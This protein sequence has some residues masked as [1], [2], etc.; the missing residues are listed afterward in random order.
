MATELIARSVVWQSKE[1]YLAVLFVLQPC[2]ILW[3]RALEAGD[4]AL[5]TG[6]SGLVELVRKMGARHMFLHGP[7]GSG[8]TFCMTEVVLKVVRHYFGERGVKAIAATNS[9]ARLLL[10]ETMHAAG[11]MTRGQSLKAKN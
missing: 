10:G 3:E 7:G 2:Q 8:K 4:M 5:L 11:K 1:Q 6:S 9:A